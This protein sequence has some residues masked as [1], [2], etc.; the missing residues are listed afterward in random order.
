MVLEAEATE[1]KVKEYR[2][3]GR[4]AHWTTEI[5]SYSNKVHLQVMFRNS[6]FG[7]FSFRGPASI[8][9]VWRNAACRW[10]E[11]AFTDEEFAELFETLRKAAATYIR[12]YDFSEDQKTSILKVIFAP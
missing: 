9:M 8:E 6:A 11:I 2:V 12:H 7:L 10:K 3:N 4:L 5:Y 1:G